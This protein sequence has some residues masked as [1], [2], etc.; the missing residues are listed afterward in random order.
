[1]RPLLIAAALLSS[2]TLVDLASEGLIVRPRVIAIRAEGPEVRVA[3]SVRLRAL[4]AVPPGLDERVFDLTWIACD[5]PSAGRP[6]ED[7]DWCA[8][9]SRER[10]ISR[11]TEPLITIPDSLPADEVRQMSFV[12]GYWHRVSAEVRSRDGQFADRA[13]KRIVVRPADIDA[14]LF[15]MSANRNPQL[16]EIE[17]VLLDSDGRES[18]AEG[19]LNA[20]VDVLFRVDPAIAEREGYRVL[21]VDLNGLSPEQI[22]ALSEEG[23]RERTSVEERRE[24][25]TLRH[26]HSD[27]QFGRSQGPNLTLQSTADA[28]QYYPAE[29]TWSLNTDGRDEALPQRVRFWFVLVD[30]RGGVSWQVVER[31]FSAGAASPRLEAMPPQPP[32]GLSAAR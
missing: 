15:T 32:P 10:V 12:A 25:L 18:V 7:Q 14:N 24:R 1:M 13:Y 8:E 2:C 29:I 3:D 19:A 16:P 4:V 31:A 9:R 27:G 26:Y 11:A 28:P 17:V 23:F 20:N 22:A 30:G 6:G 21:T 5:E